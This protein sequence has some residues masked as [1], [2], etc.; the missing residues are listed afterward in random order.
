MA[1]ECGKRNSKAINTVSAIADGLRSRE[2]WKYEAVKKFLEEKC[3]RHQ[4]EFPCGR[5][6]FD[7]ALIDF[8]TFVEFDGKYH[9]SEIQTKKDEEKR[10]GAEEFGWKV[11]RVESE[12][13]TMLD[14]S[15]LYDFLKDNVL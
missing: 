10:I 5:W 4:F 3:I 12:E 1:S 13:S 6:I 7:L 9:N 8:R 11:V 2:S 15:L 14:P